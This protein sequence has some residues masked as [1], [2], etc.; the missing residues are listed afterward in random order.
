MGKIRND[1]NADKRY[2]NSASTQSN[3]DEGQ[4]LLIKWCFK[5]PIHIFGFFFIF[6][7]FFSNDGVL[8]I[9]DNMDFDFNNN[10]HYNFAIIVGIILII[11]FYSEIKKNFAWNQEARD[12]DYGIVMR[13]L[14]FIFSIIIPALVVFLLYDYL[15]EVNW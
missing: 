10:F 7:W 4:F 9:I 15:A 6:F 11:Y 14:R 8:S 3:I 13:N 1:G 2:K 5:I 12:L